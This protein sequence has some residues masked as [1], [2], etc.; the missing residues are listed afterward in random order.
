MLDI[1][2]LGHKNFFLG[3]WY[4][5]GR[6]QV[7]ELNV[8]M[9]VIIANDKALGLTADAIVDNAFVF[10][11]EVGLDLV[12]AFRYFGIHFR[13]VV[14]RRARQAALTTASDIFLSHCIWGELYILVVH[15][16]FYLEITGAFS[17]NLIH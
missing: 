11:I 4:N 15:Y 10:S 1:G 2:I 14:F 13:R 17:E 12:R 5:N 7:F 9:R 6:I 8:L 16:D 3:N